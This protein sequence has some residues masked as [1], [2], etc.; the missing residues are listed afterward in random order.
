MRIGLGYEM[1]QC[2]PTRCHANQN[3]GCGITGSK[4]PDERCSVDGRRRTPPRSGRWGSRPI[5]LA[6]RLRFG[7]GAPTGMCPRF[8]SPRQRGRGAGARD[9][10]SDRRSSF[11]SFVRPFTGLA[12]RPGRASWGSMHELPES[13]L[14]LRAGTALMGALERSGCEPVSSS[15]HGR[16]LRK[17]RKECA[18]MRLVG[19]RIAIGRTRRPLAGAAPDDRRPPALKPAHAPSRAPELAAFDS[20]RDRSRLTEAGSSGGHRFH[21]C[22]R[23]LVLAMEPGSI[24]RSHG[25]IWQ[26]SAALR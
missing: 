13:R 7:N 3:A 23:S 9:A 15:N 1:T 16:R 20:R 8:P 2:A 4:K 17:P 21:V 19:K 26:A 5:T 24:R 12:N 14:T 11:P 6:S 10:N 18:R 25:P 22:R